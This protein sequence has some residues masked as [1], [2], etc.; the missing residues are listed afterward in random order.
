VTGPV[1]YQH[2]LL[3]TAPDSW[4]VWFPDDPKQVPWSTYLDEI[5]SAGYTYTELGPYGYMPADPAV[6]GDELARRGLVLTGGAVFAGL[7]RGQSA[8]EQARRDCDLEAATLRPLGARYIV[9]L[10][11]GY[12]DLE[13]RLVGSD[14]L[15][16]DEWASLTDGMTAL[17]AYLQQ[18][19]DLELVFHSHAD[20]HVRTYD[21]I[22]RFLR[23]TDPASVNL[24]LDTGHVAYYDG[25]NLRIIAE[26]PERIRYVHL[27]Q[28]DRQVLERARNEKLGFAPAVRLGVMTEPPLG[29]PD[30]PPLLDALEGLER[31]IF[32]IVEQDMYPCEPTKPLP[33][34]RRTRQ[35]FAS[36]G[37]SR[38]RR[39]MATP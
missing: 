28:I 18:E 14:T 26:F 15:T 32:C 21:E 22:A 37:V 36:L 1:A 30:M 20:S 38:G 2:L 10:P 4:G 3:G 27:K 13:G 17:G 23:R 16:D 25:D 24:C 9:L 5:R 11:E 19:F 6:L 31:E 35:Y 29:D 8:L 12:T 33:I 34:A 39:A 7:Q